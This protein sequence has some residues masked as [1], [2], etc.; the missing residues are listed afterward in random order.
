MNKENAQ[1][2]SLIIAI[3]QLKNGPESIQMNK[4]NRQRVWNRRSGKVVRGKLRL[5]R[6]LW[7]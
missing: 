6:H 7:G 4:G 1:G 2:S 5:I 3:Q